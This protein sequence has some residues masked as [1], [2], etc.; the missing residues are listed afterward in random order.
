MASLPD[1]AGAACVDPALWTSGDEPMKGFQASR[2]RRLCE[3]TGERF[4]PALTK[5]QATRRIS[6]LERLASA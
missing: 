3:A 1:L 4:D 2:L 6:E 5:A